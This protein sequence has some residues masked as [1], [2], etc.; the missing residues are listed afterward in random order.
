[1]IA[2]GCADDTNHRLVRDASDERVEPMRQAAVDGRLF[3]DGK[4]REAKSGRHFDVI[5]P[6]DESIVGTAADAA[7]ED[8]YDA[9][10]AA[11]VAADETSWATD[12]AFRLR[13]LRQFPDALRKESADIRKLVTAE[14]GVPA[15]VGDTQIDKQIEGMDYFN[16]LMP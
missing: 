10:T 1:M 8:V 4:F 7:P 11:R 14:A 2:I 12:H 15:A 13:C 3:I 9:V 6:A 16:G 5:N